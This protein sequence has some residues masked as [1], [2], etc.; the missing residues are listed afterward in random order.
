[1][2]FLSLV[3]DFFSLDIAIYRYIF[4]WFLLV[5]EGQLWKQ[6]G[7][8]INLVPGKWSYQIFPL[9]TISYS[10]VA[11]YCVVACRVL[12]VW[13]T[14]PHKLFAPTLPFHDVIGEFNT[15]FLYLPHGKL[16]MPM[17]WPMPYGMRANQCKKIK[18][19]L[20]QLFRQIV[21]N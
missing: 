6:K 12:N 13:M 21:L 8:D 2:D 20:N 18:M 4:K 11:S 17:I 16:T 14:I 5:N 7:I 15:F 3:V 9:V 10:V 1:M 19:N